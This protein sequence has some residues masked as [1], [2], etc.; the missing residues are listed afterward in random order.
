MNTSK[1]QKMG[2]HHIGLK[3]ADLKKSEEFYK[4]IGLKEVVRWGEGEKEIVMY[5]LGDGGR[6]ELFANGGDV[7]SANGKWI[8]FAIAVE[9]VNEAYANALAVGATPSVAPKVV[10]LDSKPQKIT[11]NVAFVKG[12]DGEELEFFK[13]L[14]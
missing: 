13:Q 7:F 11:I 3:C 14:D 2:F 9:D 12:P 4:A 6:I 5:D 10:L 8:H 1:M